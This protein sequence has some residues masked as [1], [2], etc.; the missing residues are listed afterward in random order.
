VKL[1]IT[2]AYAQPSGE[3]VTDTVT[4]NLGTICAWEDKHGTSS[5]KLANDATLDD[6]SFLFWHKL[7]KLGKENRPWEQFRDCLDE[8]INVEAASV[9]PTEAAASDA[10]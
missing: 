8:L 5:K 10:S 9:N 3:I 6:I 2:V 1:K 7:T 4:T